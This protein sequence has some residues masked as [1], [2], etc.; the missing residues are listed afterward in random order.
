MEDTGEETPVAKPK[1][2]PAAVVVKSSGRVWPPP[3]PPRAPRPSS[4]PTVPADEMNLPVASAPAPA[5]SP[6]PSAAPPMLPRALN[7]EEDEAPSDDSAPVVI[8]E[9]SS[10]PAANAPNPAVSPKPSAAPPTLPRAINLEEDEAPYGSNVDA[11]EIPDE[12]AYNILLVSEGIR[13]RDNRAFPFQGHEV[14]CDLR[15]VDNPERDR[16]LQSHLG[17]H[18]LNIQNLM[19]NEVFM[20]KLFDAMR[21]A[22]VNRVSK[23][24]LVCHSGRHR[25][26]AATDLAHLILAGIVGDD[27]IAVRHASS[28]HW[29]N[30]CQLQRDQCWNFV[31]NPPVEFHRALA[32]IRRDLQQN[33]Q[34]YMPVACDACEAVCLR[35]SWGEGSQHTCD[36]KHL[37]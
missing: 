36:S 9:E 25:S 14:W 19:V 13:F 6:K 10:L 35:L 33:C 37:R 31:H 26:V 30:I 2:A 24:R 5:V 4:S 29:H 34:P 1:L 23:V 20:R 27:N 28:K 3:T 15:D 18:P 7:L 16:R 21:E 8:A 11:I 32:E 17:Y 12:P 22:L